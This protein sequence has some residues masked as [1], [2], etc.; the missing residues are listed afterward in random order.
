MNT[1]SRLCSAAKAG[2]IIISETTMKK[3]ATKVEAISLAPIEVKGKR[4]KLRTFNV[5][6]LAGEEWV[7]DP[8]NA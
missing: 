7:K 6:G 1:A 2:E 5:V 4:D 8:T 3:V